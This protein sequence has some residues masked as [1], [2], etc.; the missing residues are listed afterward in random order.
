MRNKLFT[1]AFVVV[2]L[3][4]LLVGKAY[5][6]SALVHSIPANEEVV[7]TASELMLH[8]NEPVR[9]LRLTMT[10]AANNA[11]VLAFTPETAAKEHYMLNLP[12][13]AAGTYTVNWTLIGGD[14]HTMS[15]KMSFSVDPAATASANTNCPM[16][17]GQGNHESCSMMR[18]NQAGAAGE[19]AHGAH[20]AHDNSAMHS[21][22][23][24]E[25]H[26]HDAP[27]AAAGG[28]DH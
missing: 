3:C 20:G 28:H 18:G 14:G 4:A 22:G 26:S 19:H 27:A 17:G 9:L 2:A 23:G 5:A 25:P 10:D 7:A 13:L 8:Y 12:E 6:H 21:H 16:H 11:V 1:P 24:G 15:D